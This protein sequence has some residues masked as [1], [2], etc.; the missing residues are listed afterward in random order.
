MK[1]FVSAAWLVAMMACSGASEP[2]PPDGGVSDPLADFRTTVIGHRVHEAW[3][4]GADGT[5]LYTVVYIPAQGNGPFPTLVTRTPYDLP[6]TPVSGFPPQVGAGDDDDDD[7]DDGN[8]DDD[9]EDMSVNAV[10]VGWPEATNRGYALVIQFLRGRL[11]SEGTD[12]L[13]LGERADGDALLSWVEA[14]AFCNGRIGV[15][16]DSAAGVASLMAAASRHPSVRAIYAQA[17]TPN[18]LGGTIFPER[19]VKWEAVL[20]FALSQALEASEAHYET[21]G[22][23]EGSLAPLL[24]EAQAILGD[25]FE[26]LESGDASTSEWWMRGPSLDYPVIS[27]LQPAWR[28]LISA[29]SDP[30]LLDREDVTEA[31]DGIPTLYVSLWHDF[32]QD[33]FFDA[34]GRLTPRDDRKLMVLDGTHYDVDDPS[35]WP[36]RPMFTWFDTYLTESD[37]EARSWPNVYYSVAGSDEPPHAAEAWPPATENVTVE[38]DTMPVSLD[39]DPTH[40][41]PTL[42]G[43]HLLVASG[44]LDQRPLLDREDVARVVGRP[45]EAERFVTGAVSARVRITSAPNTDVVF[46]LVDRAPDGTLSLVREAITR[47]DGSGE[48]TIRFSPI[49]YRFAAGHSPELVV[50]GGSFPAF[51][52]LDPLEAGI[53]TLEGA[54]LTLP[55]QR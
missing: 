19:R 37:D 36:M 12:G 39:V 46:K 42:G 10:D 34:Y 29:A 32:F 2:V 38:L 50:T 25:L 30:D 7:D 48:T 47:V 54:E 33:S 5:P 18:F 35:I 11:R 16:G 44:M 17:T 31:F 20:P 1:R 4:P 22:L 14:Q 8:G 55:I 21:L 15:F 43:N 3:V 52:A 41:T 24:E 26:A 23:E 27:R 40:P 51:V 13:L 45:L 6:L 53:V 49:A 9:G 28:D